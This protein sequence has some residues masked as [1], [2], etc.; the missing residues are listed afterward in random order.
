MRQ[1]L[2]VGVLAALL[3]AALSL[4]GT[5]TLMHS[6]PHFGAG[7]EAAATAV[8]RAAAARP[9]SWSVRGGEQHAATERADGRDANNGTAAASLLSRD[10]FESDP[11][12]G[13]R[14][15]RFWFKL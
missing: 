15:P 8:A 7:P 6:R 10:Q 14:V 11:R 2:L 5:V 1:L 12:T 13:L 9:A 4:F 3:L